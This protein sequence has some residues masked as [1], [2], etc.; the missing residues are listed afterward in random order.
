MNHF[1]DLEHNEYRQVM[2]PFRGRRSPN[3]ASATHR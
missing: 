1:G 2:L 3:H